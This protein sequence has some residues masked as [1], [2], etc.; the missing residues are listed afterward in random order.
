M[1]ASQRAARSERDKGSTAL[2]STRPDTR[3]IPCSGATIPAQFLSLQRD[4]GNV[5][6]RALL[7]SNRPAPLAG[8]RI[9]RLPTDDVED[10]WAWLT[11]KLWKRLRIAEDGLDAYYGHRKAIEAVYRHAWPTIPGD[12]G[13][14]HEYIRGALNYN[15]AMLHVPEWHAQLI[16]GYRPA[17]VDARGDV[18]PAL[19]VRHKAKDEKHLFPGYTAR[20]GVH[21][22]KLEEQVIEAEAGRLSDVEMDALR[23]IIRRQL[24][25]LI[26]K[27]SGAELSAGMAT[28]QANELRWGIRYGRF[29][30]HG[31]GM[32][33]WS[34]YQPAAS[35]PQR[36]RA[37][38]Q[39]HAD[40]FDRRASKYRGRVD[41]KR[42]LID[43]LR[44][45]DRRLDAAMAR[46]LH[47]EK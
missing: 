23:R 39:Q 30:T 18:R 19:A 24:Q 4:V 8:P 46:K 15:N 34:E 3:R 36:E 44:Q 29:E 31:E 47:A 27:T 40:E 42:P 22:S 9:Q 10:F 6:V 13:A 32:G 41:P 1:V 26:D 11:Q 21:A 12:V 38:M 28:N 43:H 5:A 20:R 2:G 17:R 45:L 37:S 16:S 14:F 25:E 7:A 35:I 33:Q